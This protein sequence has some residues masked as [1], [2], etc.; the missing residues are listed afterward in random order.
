MWLILP[1]NQLCFICWPHPDHCSV[2]SSRFVHIKSP[3]YSHYSYRCRH[4]TLKL[5]CSTNSFRLDCRFPLHCIHAPV[6]V[7]D[8]LSKLTCTFFTSFQLI[9]PSVLW[10]LGGRRGIWPVKIWGEWWRW[11]LVSPDGVAPSQMVGVLIS[12][13]TIKSRSSLLA[14]ANPGG[15]RKRAVKRLW[16]GGGFS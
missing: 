4:H 8:F 12:P 15:P 13:C 6:V 1:W 10:R 9:L 14:L 7:L 2:R 11:A 3:V 16:C 5:S